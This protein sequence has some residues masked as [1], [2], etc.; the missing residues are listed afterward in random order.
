MKRCL[1]RY[2]F[3]LIVMAVGTLGAEG[4]PGVRVA[5]NEYERLVDSEYLQASYLR[6]AQNFNLGLSGSYPYKTFAIAVS[7]DWRMM[8]NNM[9]SIATNSAE[10]LLIL[11]TGRVFDENRY[12]DYL[13]TLATMRTNG[14]ISATELK[15][16][17]AS[18]RYDQMSCLIRRYRQPNI[19]NLV[20]KLKIA[21]PRTNYWDAILSGTAYTN[22]LEEARA[23]LWGENFQE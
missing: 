20:E 8:L 11:G 1:K 7:N 10:R 14:V 19:A 22:Y 21:L 4:L 13:D 17:E 18:S 12:I 2:L 23:G 15:W 16:F 5:L 9:N 3:A 6:D